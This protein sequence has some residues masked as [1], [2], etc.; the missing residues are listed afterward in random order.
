MRGFFQLL[1]TLCVLFPM[2]ITNVM[3][4]IPKELTYQGH[5]F[6]NQGA[7]VNGMIRMTFN[8]YEDTLSNQW[9]YQDVQDVNVDKGY[10]T[11][12]LYTSP[13]PRD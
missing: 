12:L 6:D 4:Q 8:F 1:V 2:T 7:P 10:Y 11:C 3:G 9:V 5:L 13:S